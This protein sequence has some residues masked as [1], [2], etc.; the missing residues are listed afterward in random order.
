MRL[1]MRPLMQNRD[2]S[3]AVE[4]A[5][6][7]PM[8][9]LLLAGLVDVSRLISHTMQVRA[10][11]QAGADW[12]QRN[13]WDATRIASA[14]TSATTLQGVSAAPAPARS[15]GCVVNGKITAQSTNCAN[16]IAPGQFVTVAARAPFKGVV[17]WPGRVLPNTLS[18]TATVRV[19]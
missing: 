1:T 2:G 17:P 6:L 4:F 9:L 15:L 10:A 3:A 18:A 12:A 7:L 5:L 19:Q 13:G 16:N 11:A 8:L 14:V